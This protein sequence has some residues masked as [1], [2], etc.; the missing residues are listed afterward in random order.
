MG[1]REEIK[2]AK[3]TARELAKAMPLQ[4]VAIKLNLD[5]EGFYHVERGNLVRDNDVDYLPTILILKG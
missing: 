3:E 2:Q 5:F 1:P 4:S